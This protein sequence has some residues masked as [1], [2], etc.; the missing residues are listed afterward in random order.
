MP[1]RAGGRATGV[2]GV[3]GVPGLP[4]VPGVPGVP[5]VPGVPG[6]GGCWGVTRGRVR[7]RARVGVRSCVGVSMGR[8]SRKA[9]SKIEFVYR[10]L[11]LFGSVAKS[12]GRGCSCFKLELD[13]Y[14]LKMA[15]FL[16]N[17]QR[18]QCF[19]VSQCIKEVLSLVYL[20]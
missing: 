1:L 13:D 2:L 20:F 12:R 7:E 14:H 9:L 5:D 4:G 18:H 11:L 3:L 17:Q 8:K 6:V 16:I 19:N 10:A 15:I